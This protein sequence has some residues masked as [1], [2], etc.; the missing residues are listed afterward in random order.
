[1]SPVKYHLPM[2][3]CFPKCE[4]HDMMHIIATK[5]RLIM[6]SPGGWRID[7]VS[8]YVLCP[9][10]AA[11]TIEYFDNDCSYIQPPDATTFNPQRNTP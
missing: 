9:D 11:G 6:S 10:H 2:S 1:V 7:S 3:C 4:A 5:Y 8:G